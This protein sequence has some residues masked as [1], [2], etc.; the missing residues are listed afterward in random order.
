MRAMVTT[1]C[2]CTFRGYVAGGHEYLVVASVGAWYRVRNSWGAQWA[3]D[4]EFWI[5]EQDLYRLIFNEQGDALGAVENP[6]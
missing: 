4:G 6:L 5:A 2:R 1:R 3:D